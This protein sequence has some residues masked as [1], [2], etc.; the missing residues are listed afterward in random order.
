MKSTG[1]S[2]PN[3]NICPPGWI[4]NGYRNELIHG[5]VS[6]GNAYALGGVAGHAGMFSSPNDV[7]LMLQELMFT[8]NIWNSTTRDLFTQVHNRT[9]SDRALGFDTNLN[10]SCGSLSPNTYT[11]TGYFG[12]QIC[13]EPH[14]KM[15][16]LLFSNRVFP[17]PSNTKIIQFRRVF[18]SEVQRIFDQLR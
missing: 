14:R 16:T 3:K 6:D 2:C 8:E 5:Y 13:L 12:T 9:Q 17:D 18:G 1:F 7:F 11:H 10:G 4:E 15:F